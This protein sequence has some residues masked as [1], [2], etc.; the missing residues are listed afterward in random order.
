[1]ENIPEIRFRGFAGEW[2]LR[3]LGDI[4][5]FK[6]GM[7][8]TKE[9]MG[10]G[11]PFVNLQD[12]FGKTILDNNELGLAVSTEKQRQEYNLKKGDVLFIRSSVKPEG[13]GE[14][15]L[16]AEDF[17]NTTYSGFI[18]RFRANIPLDN[19]FKRFV[20]TTK[21][22][23]NQIMTKATSSANTNINQD[24]LG[25]LTFNFPGEKEQQKIGNFFSTLDTTIALYKRKLDGLKKLKAGYLQQ[26]FPRAGE[27]V[28]QIRFASFD[29]DWNVRKLGEISR[30]KTGAS[31]VQDAVEGGEH[32]FFVRSEKI[33]RSSKYLFDGE[34]ILIPGE[35]R[36]GDIYHYI[37]GKFDYHQRVYKI[38][39]FT[40]SVSGIFIL[41]AMQKTFKQHA[42]TYTVKAT[43]DSLRLPMLTEFEIMLPSRSE[44]TDIG[45]FFRNLDG[46]INTQAE[47]L[48]QVKRLKSA[49][50]Q[51]MFV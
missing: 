45:N 7:N 38:S 32:P 2:E 14:T 49:Y 48:E 20:F 4:G 5:E 19:Q 21:T 25:L 23:R 50:L 9:S 6:N 46:A 41:Y 8:F 36:L 27:R 47:K 29:G 22:I 35:G 26:M 17:P 30:I 18:I 51:K 13:V 24:S 43:V 40:K 44:Q 15:A 39:D 16:V 28:P 33:E 42:M 1:M 34:A 10:H 37:N 12:I 11:H 31:D 3:K